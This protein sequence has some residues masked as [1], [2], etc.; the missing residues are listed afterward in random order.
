[1]CGSTSSLKYASSC[2]IVRVVLRDRR[3]FQT[4]AGFL[5]DRDREMR[6]LLGM[7]AGKKDEIFTGKRAERPLHGIDAVVR[8]GEICQARVAIGV[9]DRTVKTP[10]GGGIICREDRRRTEAVDRRDH[11][12]PRRRERV[13]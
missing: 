5:G 11:R 10:R 8:R 4:H 6:A 7:E 13:C 12:R 1:M 3:H 2:G 9:A